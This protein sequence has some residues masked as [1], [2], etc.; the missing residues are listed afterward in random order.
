MCRWVGG[1]F[2]EQMKSNQTIEPRALNLPCQ[3][4]RCWDLFVRTLQRIPVTQCQATLLSNSLIWHQG[5][6]NWSRLGHGEWQRC[7]LHKAWLAD[8][9]F[10]IS[11]QTR[12]D[13]LVSSLLF[14]LGKLYHLICNLNRQAQVLKDDT[15][16]EKQKCNL[17]F[18]GCSCVW[19]PGYGIHWI[20]SACQRSSGTSDLCPHKEVDDFV[21]CTLEDDWSDIPY[22]EQ[23]GTRNVEDVRD[24]ETAVYY[25]SDPIE[26]GYCSCTQGIVLLH[27][28][29]TPNFCHSGHSE[30]QSANF[31][32]WSW[33]CHLSWLPTHQDDG[34]RVYNYKDIYTAQGALSPSTKLQK[35]KMKANKWIQM[36]GQRHASSILWCKVLYWFYLCCTASLQERIM[37]TLHSPVLD[38]LGLM[39]II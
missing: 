31:W 18:V 27:F 36:A 19:L 39:L 13:V 28:F 10:T 16:S 4:K 5:D 24:A 15:V 20:T 3:V 11:M 22:E 32:R 17:C 12:I 21:P 38:S 1:S 14:Q 8:S 26:K 34:T 35:L 9:L 30:I 29:H 2:D 23:E 6:G 7:Y 37:H 33:D 25:M